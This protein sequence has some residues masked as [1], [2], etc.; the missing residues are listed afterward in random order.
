MAG[1]LTAAGA[2]ALTNAL[3]AELEATRLVPTYPALPRSGGVR[4]EWTCARCLGDV[5]W[6]WRYCGACGCRLDF[7]P[8][9]VLHTILLDA[10][11]VRIK[12]QGALLEDGDE[13]TFSHV[14]AVT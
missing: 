5:E 12:L 11:V 8:P 6:G 7:G 4:Q 3:M 1:S 9:S 14:T 2:N 10:D 13:L